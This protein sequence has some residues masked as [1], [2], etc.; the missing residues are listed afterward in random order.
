MPRFCRRRFLERLGLAGVPLL[1]PVAGRL[2]REAQGAP[3]SGR[4]CALVFVIG[5]CVPWPH[6]AI[7]GVTT[8][9]WDKKTLVDRAGAGLPLLY[10]TLERHKARTAYVDGLYNALDSEEQHGLGWGAITGLG[11]I[12]RT[13]E[14]GGQPAGV[15]LDQHIARQI[16]KGTPVVSLNF[17]MNDKS[18]ADQS[19][20]TFATG[21]NQP[22]AHVGKPSLLY[23]RILGKTGNATATADNTTPLLRAKVLD[24]VRGDVK[25]LQAELAAEE[26]A[27]L[28]HYLE[29]I[30]RFDKRQEQLRQI[31]ANGSCTPVATA[32]EGTPKQRMEAMFQMA[33]LALRC[34][35]TNV[36]GVSLG[37]GFAHSDLALFKNDLF[38]GEDYADHGPSDRYLKQML[39]VYQWAS[40][41]VAELIESSGLADNLVALIVGASG[42]GGDPQ[43]GFNHHAGPARI[44]ALVY[45]GTGTLKMGARYLSYPE[46]R[47]S[48]VDLFATVASAA[49]APTDKF[50]GSASNPTTG[51]LAELMA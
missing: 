44:P 27:R 51:V 24:S 45:D 42:S 43:Y 50:A 49:G 9:A 29:A 4:R 14:S 21:P 17:G 47:R 36:V 31:G 10:N 16:G 1:L 11:P 5:E 19:A 6:L 32:M 39:T 30:D 20:N 34:G 22:I 13:A 46:K 40:R 3:T 35:T 41:L 48:I 28:D 26:R 25:R 12:G 15:S 7:P 2:V 37:S 18:P 33:A 8:G 23:A 38:G